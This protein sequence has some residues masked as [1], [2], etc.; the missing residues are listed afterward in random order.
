MATSAVS[1]GVAV[2]LAGQW[3]R[4]AVQVASIVVLA[5]LLSPSDYGIMTM[6]MAFLGIASVIGDLGLSLASIQAKSISHYQRSNLFWI[7]TG[8]GVAMSAVGYLAAPAIAEFYNESQLIPVTQALS[9]TFLFSG[10]SA[11][12]RAEINRAERYSFLAI[13]DVLSQVL[14]FAFAVTIAVLG[15]QYWSLVGQQVAFTFS[16]L[17][18]SFIASKWLPAFPSR[19]RNM[20][21]LI[22]FGTAT[23]L[24]QILNYISVNFSSI[25]IG[26]N[27]GAILL[28]VYNRAFQIFSLPLQQ[29][30]SPLTRVALPT[31]SK[32]YGGQSYDATIRQWQKLMSYALVGLMLFMASASDLVVSIALGSE[33]GPAG[34]ILEILCLG[35]V[36]QA[37]GYVYYW[38]F[39]SAGKMGKLLLFES[40]GRVAMVVLILMAASMGPLW[41]AAAMSVGQFLIWGLVSIFGL[42]HVRVDSSALLK[43]TLPAALMFGSIYGLIRFELHLLA[44]LDL[45]DIQKMTLIC[46]SWLVGIAVT[47]SFSKVVRGD[48]TWIINSIR[49]LRS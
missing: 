10:I 5:R 23:T 30:A 8:V 29:I 21:S 39:L 13:T 48:I 35:G 3:T 41:I 46:G 16:V 45:S 33:W 1:G 15:G 24:T 32:A 20:R 28:G 27:S 12:F 11:Q 7:N 25:I 34:V 26:R 43:S 17:I 18:F 22:N 44:P 9:I 4:Y 38:I 19:K 49:R 47:C 42:S 31:L 6:A 36:F 37:L 2:T 14:A 40:I